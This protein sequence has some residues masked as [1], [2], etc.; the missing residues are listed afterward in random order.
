MPRAVPVALTALVLASSPVLVGCGGDDGSDVAPRTTPTIAFQPSG[1]A[2]PPAGTTT[3][4]V[5]TPAPDDSGATTT[6][7]PDAPSGSTEQLTPPDAAPPARTPT[8]TTVERP[9]NAVF[10]PG[11][12][13]KGVK[14]VE[15]FDTR[16]LLGLK[17]AEAAARAKKEGCA[18]R[19]VRR[20]GQDLAG[21]MDFSNTR[22]NV[23]ETKGRIVRI[24]S[25][26]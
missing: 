26:G 2:E 4:T 1:P 24:V 12:S 13:A 16:V 15:K 7:A 5:P 9:K 25:I 21:T 22:V 23:T 3:S 6:T 18:M 17:T 20:D 14:A 8:E 10:C 11:D 19:V